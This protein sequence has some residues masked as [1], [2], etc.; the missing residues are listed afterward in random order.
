VYDAIGFSTSTNTR[1][2]S[3]TIIGQ[4]RNGIAL[5]PPF[6]P[7]PTGNAAITGNHVSGALHGHSAFRND[8]T[9]FTGVT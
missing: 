4:W 8:S 7:A 6:Y 1:L 3:K 9:G 5:S 2:A